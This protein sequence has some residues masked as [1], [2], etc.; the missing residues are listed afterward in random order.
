MS[1]KKIF[2]IFFRKF[3]PKHVW[4]QNQPSIICRSQV[5]VPK[6]RQN[7]KS[8]FN[9]PPRAPRAKKLCT[10]MFHP[11][12]YLHAENDKNRWDKGVKLHL[13]WNAPLG[14]LMDWAYE[15]LVPVWEQKETPQEV[16][17][18]FEPANGSSRWE[19]RFNWKTR[20]P[21]ASSVRFTEPVRTS[22][23]TRT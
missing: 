21:S 10:S 7:F 6:K 18:R 12:G 16:P 14:Q 8:S 22:V 11:R 17:A 20:S 15:W 9:T 5:M 19:V 2:K 13:P 3:I 23:S 1:P 4:Y